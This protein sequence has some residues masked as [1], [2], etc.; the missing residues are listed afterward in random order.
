[1]RHRKGIDLTRGANDNLD[2]QPV[3]LRVH[4]PE[5]QHSASLAD[6][7]E[8]YRLGAKCPRCK[9]VSWLDCWAL[10]RKYGKTRPVISLEPFLVCGRCGNRVG[11]DF[12][13]GKASRD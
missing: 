13:V 1:M 9:H 7:P 2:P 5:R 8:W 12:V 11:N 10:A 4:V 3:G 6:L